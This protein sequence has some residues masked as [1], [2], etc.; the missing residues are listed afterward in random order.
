M[1]KQ[2]IR[3]LADWKAMELR[4]HI[5]NGVESLSRVQTL[6]ESH[7]MRPPANV[8]EIIGRKLT[9]H[10]RA[11]ERMMRIAK[12]WPAFARDASEALE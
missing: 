2:D 8:Y 5:I 4:A 7:G 11:M 10:Q 9:S 3:V 1:H 6:S 12:G